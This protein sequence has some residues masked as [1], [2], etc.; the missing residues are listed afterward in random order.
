MEELKPIGSH[1][2]NIAL[3]VLGMILAVSGNLMPTPM[4]QK[5]LY[6]AASVCLTTSAVLERLN[7]FIAFQCV[8][9]TGTL[10]AF[11]PLAAHVKLITPL[12]VAVV[13]LTIVFTKQNNIDYHTVLGILGIITLAVGY[14]V[15]HPAAYFAGSVLLAIYSAIAFKRGVAIAWVWTL[16]NSIFAVTAFLHFF[17]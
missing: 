16:L 13:A 7:F 2:F 10:I 9:L 5:S 15:T 4:L 14:S 8:I 1:R 3:A 17:R 11:F 6:L 12:I